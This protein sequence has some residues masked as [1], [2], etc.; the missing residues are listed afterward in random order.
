[1]MSRRSK[2]HHQ[3]HTQSQNP[4][5]LSTSNH[6]DLHYLRVLLVPSAL[7]GLLVLC[8]P[9]PLEVRWHLWGLWVPWVLS[10]RLHLLIR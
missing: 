2:L 9:V 5:C 8:L 7:W 10:A 4:M 6:R 1:M 3:Q